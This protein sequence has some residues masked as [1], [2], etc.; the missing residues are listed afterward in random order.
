M[1]IQRLTLCPLADKDIPL[2]EEWLQKDYILQWYHSAEDWL[3]EIKGRQGQYSWLHHFIVVNAGLPIGF[4]QYYDCYDAN[5]IEDWYQVTRPH[6]T[7]SIDYLIGSEA[8][9]GKG[10][11]KAIV[12]LVTQAVQQTGRA[13]QIIVQPEEENHASAHVLLANG[14][15]YNAQN[16]YYR[17]KLF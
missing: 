2:M 4:C 16:K 13:K 8:H 14:Y 9:L 15:V 10:Y 11:G 1:S 7:Y 12:R 6:H 5:P 3:T 17:K